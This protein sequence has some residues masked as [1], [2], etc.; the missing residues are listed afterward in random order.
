VSAERS[1]ANKLKHGSGFRETQAVWLDDDLPH[2]AARSAVDPRFVVIGLR[3]G[4][5]WSAVV[6]YRGEADRL[7]SVRRSRAREVEAHEGQ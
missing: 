4:K 2:M 5:L 3:D 7:T 1:R 6:T